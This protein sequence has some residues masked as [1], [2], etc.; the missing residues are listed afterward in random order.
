MKLVLTVLADG[1]KRIECEPETPEHIAER[2]KLHQEIRKALREKMNEFADIFK[3]SPE[4]LMKNELLKN[5]K[6]QGDCWIW[7][8]DEMIEY[9]G[10]LKSVY[11]LSYIV[12]KLVEI[13]KGKFICHKCD[14]KKC[15]NPNHLYTCSKKE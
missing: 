13:P 10:E 15:I 8:K 5:I 9:E 11:E 1:S 6:K 4:E 7:T 12:F 14:S 3:L 2:R